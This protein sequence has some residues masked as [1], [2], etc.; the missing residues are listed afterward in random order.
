MGAQPSHLFK[1][2]LWLLWTL[3]YKAEN[4]L[5]LSTERVC[6]LLPCTDV[7]FGQS[8]I[9]VGPWWG[10]SQVLVI[11]EGA[12]NSGQFSCSWLLLLLHLLPQV[13]KKSQPFTVPFCYR[14]P[15]PPKNQ[16]QGPLPFLHP[17]SQLIEYF[18]GSLDWGIIVPTN[19]NTKK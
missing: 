6:W 9:R 10:G 7:D 2:C 17:G 1:Y 4:T 15:T 5:W 3:A 14:L 13:L 16:W 18:G 19:N 12:G 11:K 8:F